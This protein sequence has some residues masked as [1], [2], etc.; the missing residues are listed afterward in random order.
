MSSDYAKVSVSLPAPLVERIRNKVGSRGVSRYVA[1]ALE[2]EERRQ[3][4]RDWLA[5][6]DQEHGTIP[7]N[8]M[9]EVRRQWLGA[10]SVAS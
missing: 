5:G 7:D 3:A 2:H 8:V 1:E 6:Q 9:Q 4:L 10:D